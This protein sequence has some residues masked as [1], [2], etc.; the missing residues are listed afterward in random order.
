MTQKG[1]LLSLL[2]QILRQARELIP[3]ISPTRWEALCL[4]GDDPREL[5]EQ[6][7]YHMLRSVIKI[8]T[9]SKKTCLFVDGL[10]EL[11]GHH[12]DL[13][14]LFKDLIDNP[15]TK[16]CVSSRPWIVFEDAFKHKPSL[17]LQDLIYPDIQLY[18]HSCLYDNPGFVQHAQREPAYADQLA[19][20]IIRKASGVFL[21]VNLVVASLLSGMGCGDRIS[22][23][24]KRLEAL[25]PDLELLYKKFLLSQDPFYLE[26]AA[27]L[28]TLVRES[29]VP[30][31]L[32]LLSFADEEDPQFAIDYPIQSLS[33]VEISLRSDTMRRRL[34][35]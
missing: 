27:Q 29:L 7:L 10:D 22:D 21:W 33:D 12:E 23:L 13:I 34:N 1:L 35:S 31:S 6:E 30:P 16:I 25:P 20:N 32:L 19:D 28:F 15:N 8:L 14:C 17:G 9:K 2:H 18:V 5:T 24:Q 26:H 4:F 11:D 3:S